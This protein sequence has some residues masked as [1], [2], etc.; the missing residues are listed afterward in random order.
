MKVCIRHCLWFCHSKVIYIVIALK[1]QITMTFNIKHS[2][3]DLCPS[4]T[5][6]EVRKEFF[7]SLQPWRWGT[8]HRKHYWW[9]WQE[10]EKEENWKSALKDT[11]TAMTHTVFTHLVMSNINSSI[12]Y[13]KFLGYLLHIFQFAMIQHIVFQLF[14]CFFCGNFA[15]FELFCKSIKT[16]DFEKLGRECP[17]WLSGNKSN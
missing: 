15:N 7:P 10:E 13:N 8:C 3:L 2:F 14:S 4:Q 17:L 12:N 6:W 5:C 11:C 9:L 16:I 1:P